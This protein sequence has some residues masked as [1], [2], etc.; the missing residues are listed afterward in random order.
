MFK[1]YVSIQN[2]IILPLGSKSRSDHNL[3]LNTFAMQLQIVLTVHLKEISF[4]NWAFQNHFP[5]TLVFLSE[6][7]RE[8]WK[9][10][11]RILKKK[12]IIDS[13]TQNSFTI[14]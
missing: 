1:T 10:I 3:P 4:N 6:I 11:L 9:C 13:G 8:Y 12:K 14:A 2:I 7:V 5:Y